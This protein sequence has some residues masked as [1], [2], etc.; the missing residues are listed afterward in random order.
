MK[1][2]TQKFT[3]SALAVLTAVSLCACNINTSSTEGKTTTQTTVT[4]DTSEKA[5]VSNE[6]SE[7]T[8][9]SVNGNSEDTQTGTADAVSGNDS[10]N[11]AVT[12]AT[13]T[14]AITTEDG[15][16]TENGSIYTITS[17]GTYVL[18]GVLANGQVIVTAGEDEEVELELSGV[19][20][21][22]DDD[23]PIY[24][25]S[26]GKVKIKAVVGTENTVNDVRPLQTDENDT[27]GTAAIYALCDLNIVG[28]G[29]LTVTASYNN[30]I[31]TKDD[32]KIKNLTLSVAAPNNALKGNDSV[33][34][35]SGTLKILST[36]GDGIKTT[37]SDV[38]EK[39][40]QRGIVTIAGGT[41]EIYAAVDGIDAAYDFVMTDGS[42]TVNAQDDAV[43]AEQTVQIDGGYIDV[44]DSHEG[45]EG[46]YVTIN[47]GEIHVYADDDGINATASSN[48]RA[49]GMITVNGG[50][51]YVEVSGRDVDGLDSN[52]SYYQTGGFVVVSNPSANGGGMSGALDTDGTV[53]VTGGVILALGGG[54]NG[55]GGQQGGFGGQQGPGN[56]GG[57]HGPG[58]MGGQH[59][60]G[61]MSDDSSEDYTTELLGY[62]GMGGGFGMG[63]MMMGGSMP[64]GAVSY[65][66]TLSAGTH[67]FTYNGTTETFT[68]KNAVS[69][70]WIWASGIS[71]NNYTLN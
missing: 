66:G 7:S 12:T 63:G 23:S 59:G 51:V 13:G 54:A 41:I 61:N 26:A 48:N 27:T 14:F 36:E 38:S 68:L 2:I 29:K 25:Y 3:A 24:V 60:P 37:N 10:A 62:G 32:L 20:I 71:A 28:T 31:H 67:T 64:S 53:S 58:S 40:N 56:M 19:S 42:L 21:T 9:S 44:T 69:G 33:T 30:G 52:G 22:C 45:I 5:A 55:M 4:A 47:D 49:D 39:G 17:G 50:K 65:T 70:G 35:E 18:T 16:V 43:H 15:N 8:A 11:S 46:H 34:I 1:K 57:Q 6:A